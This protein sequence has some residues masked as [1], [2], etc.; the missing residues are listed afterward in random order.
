MISITT[1]REKETD[2]LLKEN[3][4]RSIIG[5]IQA[6]S[7]EKN[8]Q[9]LQDMGSRFC[10]A[11]NHREVAT[12]IMRRFQQ[13]GYNNA[14]LDSFY[15]VK[16]FRSILYE[17]IQYN[18]IAYIEG[19]EYPDSLCVM[20]GHYDDVVS[21]ADLSVVPGANDNASG[22]AAVLETARVLKSNNF[23]PKSTIMFVAFGA[24]EMGLYGSRD[25]AASP[26][27]YTGM[28]RF[29]L[30]SD[31]IAFETSPSPSYWSVNIIDYDN[32]HDLR[33]AA[34]E[35]C[36]K[37]TVLSFYNSNTYNKQSD[38]YPFF[39]NGYKALF[40]FSG[41]NDT[42]YHTYYDVVTNC[43]FNYCAEIVKLQCAL[44]ADRN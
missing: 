24:E 14:K 25:F 28:I 42:N 38:S 27:G 32:S 12:S 41:D 37:Y 7:I 1:C 31:M 13:M 39:L 44:L 26:E 6:D 20:G 3:V 15:V 22:T 29:M 10:F 18:V 2:E 11:A 34:E 30:N 43:N 40:F 36:T 8:V 35:I 9:W 33:H 19:T 5:D 17:Q 23:K 21:T 16:T 4:I